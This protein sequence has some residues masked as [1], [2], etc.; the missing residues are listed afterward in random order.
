MN[1]TL[2]K[3]T[4]FQTCE[5]HA[6]LASLGRYRRAEFFAEGGPAGNTGCR[7][8]ICRLWPGTDLFCAEVCAGEMQLDWTT[9]R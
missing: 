5:K 8:G 7:D 6:D 4:K 9:P 3:V 1:A 2:R